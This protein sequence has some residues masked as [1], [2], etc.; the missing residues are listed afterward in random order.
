MNYDR[1]AIVNREL[2]YIVYTCTLVPYRRAGGRG[3]RA[4][5]ASQR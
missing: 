1:A 3:Q 5:L 2:R 4:Q